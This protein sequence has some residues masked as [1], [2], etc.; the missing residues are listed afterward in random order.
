[1]GLK[2][3]YFTISQAAK[4]MGVTRQTISRWI[5]EG[6][7]PA[8]KIGREVL[9]K[10]DDLRKYHWDKLTEMAAEN[11]LAIYKAFLKGYYREKGR[12]DVTKPPSAEDIAEMEKHFGPILHHLVEEFY[13]SAKR[14]IYPKN[15]QKTKENKSK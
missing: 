11:I 3:T 1:M 15:N 6:K 4:Q 8:E 10:K 5:E 14:K 13:Q 2:D 7:F 12:P 9:I